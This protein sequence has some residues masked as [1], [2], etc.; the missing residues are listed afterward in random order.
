MFFS[1]YPILTIWGLIITLFIAAF[2]T[3]YYTSPTRYDIDWTKCEITKDFRLTFYES[4]VEVIQLGDRNTV[5][6]HPGTVKNELKYICN[7]VPAWKFINEKSQEAIP[8][9][10][11]RPPN[12]FDPRKSDKTAL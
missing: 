6:V 3:A 5:K 11:K 4:W 9:L 10:P 8:T 1:K 7:N 12:P 2:S